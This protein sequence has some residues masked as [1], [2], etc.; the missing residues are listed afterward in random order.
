MSGAM[1]RLRHGAFRRHRAWR[2]RDRTF[3]SSNLRPTMLP[4]I[5]GFRSRTAGGLWPEI[6]ATVRAQRPDVRI[7]IMHMNPIRG[8]RAWLRPRREQFEQA[9]RELARELGAEH[10]DFSDRWNALSAAERE[11]AIPDGTHPVASATGRIVVPELV[12]LVSNGACGGDD[13]A[14]AREDVSR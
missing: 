12:R 8:W 3:C 9:H 7:V 5:A 13:P 10:V 4:S 1:A 14:S 2:N 11:A 6:V